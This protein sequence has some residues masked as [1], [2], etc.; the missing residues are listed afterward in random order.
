MAYPKIRELYFI[1]THQCN[2]E[3]KYCFVSQNK[4]TMS[5][6]TAF[7]GIDFLV[8][9]LTEGQQAT[10]NF[11]GGEPL[12]R[13]SETVVPTVLYAEK[14]YPGKIRFNI[15]SNCVL[16]DKE[17]SDFI[18]S[19]KM[20]LLTSFDGCKETQD[21]NRPFHS[22]TGSFDIVYKN[23]MAHKANGATLGTMRATVHPGSA[24]L[25]FE[26]YLQAIDMGYKS[27]FF[28]T[29][30]FS[31]FTE[32]QTAAYKAGLY[33][34]ADHYINYWNEHN[35]A[36]IAVSI[37]ERDMAQAFEDL[38]R[39]E[40]GLPI[41]MKPNSQRCGYGQNHGAAMTPSGDIYTCQQ[42][43]SNAGP[44]SQWWIGNVRTGVDDSRRAALLK[45]YNELGERQGDMPCEE[46]SARSI[47]KGGC[48]ATNH[49]IYENMRKN[50]PTWCM[51]LRAIH[52]IDTYITNALRNNTAFRTYLDNLAKRNRTL[53][54]TCQE[55]QAKQ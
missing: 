32:E 17:K 21:Y 11:F 34:L 29:D 16:L 50:S 23:I 30:S 5:C 48:A 35:K 18:R 10:V 15:T 40:Q 41:I 53:C 54:A 44:D 49:L 31:E 51:D 27:I 8:N 9:N 55:N 6:E 3:C 52:E 4:A 28:M 38:Q 14:M 42:L 24:H 2:L 45:I 43:S 37:L 7:A 39:T 25:I 1:L 19:H 47:C 22:G 26:N 20:G 13:W 46:C 36:P 33:K 12:L